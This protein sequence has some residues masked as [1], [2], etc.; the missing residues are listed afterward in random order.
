M[1]VETVAEDRLA[2]AT[3]ELQCR[4]ELDHTERKIRIALRDQQTS[5][6]ITIVADGSGVVEDV[7]RTGPDDCNVALLIDIPNPDDWTKSKPDWSEVPNRY[8]WIAQDADGEYVAYASRPVLQDIDE[9]GCGIGSNGFHDFGMYPKRE[10]WYATLERRPK[11]GD[12]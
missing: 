7:G 8:N 3:D 5:A 12:S 11:D 1:R 2:I 10:G 4:V 9:W 6:G